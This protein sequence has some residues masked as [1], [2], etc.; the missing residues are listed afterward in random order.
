MKYYKL[1]YIAISLFIF[2]SCNQYPQKIER[3]N[4]TP[5]IITDELY[6]SKKSKLIKTNNLFYISDINEIDGFIKIYNSS[7]AFNTSIGK[8]GDGPGEFTTPN[9]ISY[10]NDGVLVWNK[11]G[12]F[13]SAISK[14]AGERIVL[15]PITMPFINENAASLQTDLEGNFIVYNPTKKE[16]I[17]TLYSKDG[18]E[19]TSAGKLPYPQEIS[20]RQE[21]FSG[22]I[23]Y[24]PYNKKLVL[25][26][27]T[28]PYVSVYQIKN[29]QITLLNEQEIGEVEYH[30]SD[31]NMN[32]P[33]SGKDCLVGFCLTK[34]YIVSV[35]NDPDYTGTD[36]SQTSPKRHTVG[37][38]DYN[39]N[40][41][42][43]VNL[44]M[45]RVKLAA[46]GKD[47]Y[48]YA[49]VLNPEYSIAKVKL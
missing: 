35:L 8:I 25:A 15:S 19:I 2:I 21:S 17:I 9:I 40:L 41:V 20:N 46:Q 26:L 47:N 3:V 48:F 6:I 38:Y 23:I 42:K 37:V 18:K 49:I 45:P 33:N 1:F 10:K 27:N 14:K 39:L 31:N 7:G 5:E 11:W 44:N 36:R 34:D 30:V 13:N 22:E 12:R 29:N 16:G 43:I 4:V 24:N 32:I 28:L